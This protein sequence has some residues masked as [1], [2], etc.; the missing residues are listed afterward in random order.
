AEFSAVVT[1]AYRAL[2]PV[3]VVVARKIE[4]ALQDLQDDEREGESVGRGSWA[5]ETAWLISLK[6]RIKTRRDGQGIISQAGGE[7][8]MA[9]C[10]ILP[11]KSS[12][13]LYCIAWHKFSPQGNVLG[14]MR[15]QKTKE[16]RQNASSL[17]GWCS[18]QR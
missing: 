18:K 17:V 6:G 5:W 11:G 1:Q 16:R 15:S 8:V 2:Y 13:Y 10:T 9:L 3:Q 7:Q 4:L 12:L 14:L